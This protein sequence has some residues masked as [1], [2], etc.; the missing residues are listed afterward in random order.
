M[1]DLAQPPGRWPALPLLPALILSLAFALPS[2]SLAQ[3][4]PH[5]RDAQSRPA[6]GP[7]PTATE[8]A[9]APDP[10]PIV[11]AMETL[12]DQVRALGAEIEQ[13]KKL[14]PE[15]QALRDELRQARSRRDSEPNAPAWQYLSLLLL[16]S[17]TLALILVALARQSAIR[18]ESMISR[19]LET[20]PA[21]ASSAWSQASSPATDA[22]SEV[23][24]S[25]QK[26]LADVALLRR[27]VD[28]LRYASSRR[29]DQVVAPAPMPQQQQSQP[30][31]PQPPVSELDEVLRDFHLMASDPTSSRI[32]AFTQKWAP[33][34][35]T[36]IN[37]DQRVDEAAHDPDLRLSDGKGSKVHFWFFATKPPGTEG[38]LLPA[39]SFVQNPSA[40]TEDTTVKVLRP[41]FAIVA[42]ESFKV[43]RV[44]R[45]SVSG[46]RVK[47]DPAGTLSVPR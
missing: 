2:P 13:L 6:A 39:K 12:S 11:K 26:Q 22:V 9:G 46:S 41:I 27:E 43:Q 19:P 15:I 16:G 3:T 31:G 45:A 7:H 18:R 10:D 4:N 36:M 24:R 44:A 21:R 1:M 32:D 8:P 35:V 37:F 34:E 42:G 47:V 23:K 20:A 17:A 14:S 29:G 25:L 28:E 38:Y 30:V 40:L 5:P 33:K